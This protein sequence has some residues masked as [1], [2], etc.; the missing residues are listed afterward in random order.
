[1][2]E[3]LMRR[4]REE[5]HTPTYQDL[6]RLQEAINTP[7]EERIAQMED[8]LRAAEHK[9]DEVRSQI[10][11][12]ILRAE[13]ERTHS[14]SYHYARTKRDAYVNPLLAMKWHAFRKGAAFARS[15]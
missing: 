6:V 3:E 1:M 15:S 7:T 14:D 9:L 11:E 10:T 2:L 12:S 13:F 4:C 5:G 8:A